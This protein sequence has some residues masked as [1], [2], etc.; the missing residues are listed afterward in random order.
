MKFDELHSCECLRKLILIG[1]VKP[2]DSCKGTTCSY[3]EEAEEGQMCFVSENIFDEGDYDQSGNWCY[4]FVVKDEYYPLS[5]CPICG[6]KI[7]YIKEP[8]FI[9]SRTL[10]TKNTSK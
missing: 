1:M 7:E 6:K 8:I 2:F 5:F 9:Q 3:L 4:H 10:K